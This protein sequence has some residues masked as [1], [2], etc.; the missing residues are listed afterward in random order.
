MQPGSIDAH[1]KVGTEKKISLFITGN[2][3]L[4]GL[5]FIPCSTVALSVGL[6]NDTSES[7]Q[8][9]LLWEDVALSKASLAH[10]EY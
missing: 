5:S 7:Q 2:Q 4:L 9:C 1:G 3:K 8:Q 10:F 6:K